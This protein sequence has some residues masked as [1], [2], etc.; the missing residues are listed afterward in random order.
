MFQVKRMILNYL[1]YIMQ[2]PE[3]SLLYSMLLAQRETP[4]KN[5]FYQNALSIITEFGIEETI[6]QNK[7]TNRS[8]FFF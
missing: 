6:D 8:Q 4:D 5:D 1:H 7:H 2:Q 3:D